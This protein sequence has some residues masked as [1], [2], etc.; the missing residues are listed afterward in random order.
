MSNSIVNNPTITNIGILSSRRRPI[1]LIRAI[2]IWGLVAIFYFYD[3][4]LQ[5]SPSAMKPELTMAFT[6]QA[7]QFGSLSA[8]CL[9]AYGLMQIPA[10]I[11][12]DRFGPRRIITV[13]CGLC[14]MGSLIFGLSDSLWMAKL[15]RVCIGAGA[16]FALLCCLKVISLWFPRTRYALMTGFTVTVGYLGGAFG[17]AFVAKMV[18]SLGWRET[19]YF[20]AG[21]GLV[22]CLLLWTIVQEKQSTVEPIARD[23]AQGNA[24]N[25]IDFMDANDHTDSNDLN[26]SSIKT[27]VSKSGSHS[28][29][30]W[31]DLKYIVQNKQTWIAALFAG[32]MF[33][34]TLALGGLWG[35]PFLMEAHNFDRASAGICASLM[36]LGWVFGSAIWGFLSDYFGRRNI[37]M[38]VG[39]IVTLGLSLAIIYLDHLS[40]STLKTLF[41]ALGF[42]S[43]SF[44]I[45]FAVV[46]ENNPS[47]LAA[48]AS[49][50]TNALNT[51]WGAL[52]QPFIGFI[53]DFSANSGSVGSEV[54][55]AHQ[56]LQSGVEAGFTLA[57][58]QQAFLTL[59]ICLAISFIIL[60]F[61]KETYCDRVK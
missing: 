24:N 19:M 61:L 10:G 56:S 60:L 21:I 36:Y 34:P 6:N 1:T 55:A 30:L 23:K 47:K 46:A 53:L 57:Q 13:A 45:A 49:G 22:L 3:N 40:L 44:L 41:F 16:S 54:T 5:V 31:I 14:A 51:L 25:S 58:Y 32:L 18:E 20:G 43:S 39:N 28:S 11:L 37:P 35:I 12:L 33:V 7:E 59:P 2:S 27:I 26:E 52:A 42:F 4:L 17:L 38:M 15:G 50:F 8:Y 9:Y 48:T 29:H